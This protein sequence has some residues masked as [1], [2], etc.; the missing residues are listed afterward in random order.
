MS[1]PP[2]EV[3]VCTVC[4][5][6]T[7]Q[8]CS[9][10]KLSYFCSIE[11]QKLIWPVHRFFC[12][13]EDK[14]IFGVP[15]LSES[16][17]GTLQNAR[18][19]VFHDGVHAPTI[20]RTLLQ[21][22]HSLGFFVAQVGG[23]DVSSSSLEDSHR[24]A[25]IFLARTHL[26][27][28]TGFGY[29]R[30]DT[31]SIVWNMVAVDTAPLILACDVKVQLS[32]PVSNPFH[33][34][35]KLLHQRLIARTISL[36][37]YDL[38]S[39]DQIKP[40]LLGL[41][42]ELDE[43]A[44]LDE[45]KL[46]V[47]QQ[48]ALG[49][50]LGRLRKQC[51]NIVENVGLDPNPRSGSGSTSI[52]TLYSTSS[53]LSNRT[54]DRISLAE[55]RS[56]NEGAGEK[57]SAPSRRRSRLPPSTFFPAITLATGTR[58]PPGFRFPDGLSIGYGAPNVSV[59]EEESQDAAALSLLAGITK[60]ATSIKEPRLSACILLAR[61]HLDGVIGVKTNI[62]DLVTQSWNSFAYATSRLITCQHADLQFA[63][64][65]SN[66]FYRLSN[67]F[68]EELISS[69]LLIRSA[70]SQLRIDFTN[71]VRA[72]DR[73]IAEA[74]KLSNLAPPL[75]KAL[76]DRVHM[77]R[78]HLS[79]IIEFMKIPVSGPD[80]PLVPP[81]ICKFS[82][83]CPTLQAGRAQAAFLDRMFETVGL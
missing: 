35:A 15:P 36:R 38:S 76:N 66:P 25:C 45:T 14:T 74:A 13:S 34:F 32:D 83:S 47:Q 62:G 40:K 55:Q 31:A 60:G 63:S 46:S 29:S 69:T 64:F 24:T 37:I 4:D 17:I 9:G 82:P 51:E 49:E 26:G 56:S 39:R 79:M 70:K 52:A 18:D 21:T 48:T 12:Q 19:V 11:H 75:Q 3:Q 72:I 27:V 67:Y 20:R 1:S 23:S 5:S 8:A 42:R 54:Y 73:A 44:K 2:P 22:V 68:H 28:N 61:G 7:T 41:T 50:H 30:A 16:E 71:G 53:W 77:L 59:I 80:R 43:G 58:L 78:A 81:T 57:V 6:T 33:L 65:E 10:C